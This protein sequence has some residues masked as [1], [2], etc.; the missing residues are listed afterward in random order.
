MILFVKG[1]I[2]FFIC[3]YVSQWCTDTLRGQK[4]VPDYLKPNL[5]ATS[6]GCWEQI[7]NPLEEQQGLLIT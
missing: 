1:F 5:R 4:R 7:S 6:C 3:V 2:L